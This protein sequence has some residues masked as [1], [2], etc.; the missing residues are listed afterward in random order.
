MSAANR[1]STVAIVLCTYN[2]AR[3]LQAQLDSLINQTWPIC[4]IA[5]D[6]GSTDNTVDILESYNDRLDISVNSNGKNLGYV[7]NFEQGIS[8]ALSLGFHYIALCDQDDVWHEQRI[9]R[10][11]QQLQ[12][13]DA[14]ANSGPALA[15]SD[16][17]MV[18]SNGNTVHQSFFSYRDYSIGKQSALATVLGQNGVMGNTV[19]MNAALAKLALPFPKSLHVHDYW[20]AVLV[21]LYGQRVLLD[22]ALVNYRIHE[23]NASNPNAAIKFGMQKHTEHKSWQGFIKRDYRLPFKEDNRLNIINFILNSDGQ[24]PSITPEQRQKIELFRDYLAFEK[25][26]YK[27]LYG[28]LKGGFFRRGIKHRLRVIYST[29]FTARYNQQ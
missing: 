25:P 4:V 1:K 6:D 27:L 20:L 12:S 19:L 10:G 24:L 8:Q 9:A 29:L 13:I 21:E 5:F 3:H 14:N 15:H 11:M 7:D 23:S 26:R 18:D 22:D 17:K 2:G 16:L 28:M